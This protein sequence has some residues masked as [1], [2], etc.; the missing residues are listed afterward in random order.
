MLS[1][2][3]LC[4]E[5][6]KR[7]WDLPVFGSR[8]SAILSRVHYVLIS[9]IARSYTPPRQFPESNALAIANESPF[10]SYGG[11]K[12][13]IQGSDAQDDTFLAMAKLSVRTLS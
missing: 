2:L 4:E 10:R 12:I 8:L 5:E 13:T 11:R 1:P 7:F 3:L 9:R 6:E